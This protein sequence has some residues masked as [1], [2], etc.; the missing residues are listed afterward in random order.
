MKNKLKHGDEYVYFAS[1]RHDAVYLT[2]VEKLKNGLHRFFSTEY[3][4]LEYH[5]NDRISDIQKTSC[6][7]VVPAEEYIAFS[8]EQ[9]KSAYLLVLKRRNLF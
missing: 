7:D 4:S 8:D 5:L 1:K 2:Y 9:K 3:P 6:Y